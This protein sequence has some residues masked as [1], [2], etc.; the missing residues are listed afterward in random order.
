MAHR[1]RK[2]KA[3]L[4]KSKTYF[5]LYDL[6]AYKET[7]QKELG[8]IFLKR[9]FKKDIKKIKIPVLKTPIHQS[10]L[11]NRHSKNTKSI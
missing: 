4:S 10:L 5:F 7:T 3:I 9:K 6:T 8:C 11:P 1:C 2:L